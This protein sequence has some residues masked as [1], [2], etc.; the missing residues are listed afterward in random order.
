MGYFDDYNENMRN[1]K[2]PYDDIPISRGHAPRRT[3]RNAAPKIKILTVM[4]AILFILNIVLCCTTFYFLKNS[5]SKTVNVYYNE[6]KP[7]QESIS[8]YAKAEAKWSSVC[9]AA[10][11]SCND[12][13]SFFHNTRSKGSGVIY[14]I[15]KTK[16]VI[17]FLTCNHVIDGHDNIWVMLPSQLDPIKVKLVPAAAYYDIAVLSYE[18]DD[19]DDVLDSCTAVKLYDTTYLSEGEDVFAVGNPL[20]GGFSITTGV[21][22]RLN[23]MITIDTNRYESREIQTSADI[24]PGNSGGGLFNYKGEL[25]GIVN[26]K[27]ET[28]KSGTTTITVA[29]TAYAI[30]GNLAFGIADSIIENNSRATYVDLGVTFKHDSVG[31]TQNYEPYGSDYKFVESYKVLVES[32]EDGSIAYRKLHVGDVVESIEF[33]VLKNGNIVH[34][35]VKMY[36]KFV[37][38]DYSYSIIK[39]SNI[40]FNIKTAGSEEPKTIVIEASSTKEIAW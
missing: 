23:T 17:Y 35:V 19:V 15:D 34:V 18:T 6:L 2:I 33:D 40:K 11:G 31:V 38:E 27:L 16:G 25:V 5:K 22:S 36:N 8:N 28:A 29:G 7:T 20:S 3:E 14:K 37:F 26:A 4:V 24:N 12:Y 10:G 9:I 30:P 21:V 1:E 13:D 39:N 32:V